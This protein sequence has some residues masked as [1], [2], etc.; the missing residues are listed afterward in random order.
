M[1]GIKAT[2][3]TRS[4]HTHSASTYDWE[5]GRYY[6][7]SIRKHGLSVKGLKPNIYMWI[8]ICIDIC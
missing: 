2:R 3:W 8:Y 5:A 4:S 6:D 7:Q 1:K